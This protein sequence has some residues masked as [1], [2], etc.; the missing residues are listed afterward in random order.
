VV[1]TVSLWSTLVQALGSFTGKDSKKDRRRGRG[2]GANAA[3]PA[4]NR[5]EPESGWLI[6]AVVVLFTDSDGGGKADPGSTHAG[7]EQLGRSKAR[8]CVGDVAGE[9]GGG[10]TSRRGG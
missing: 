3:G 5:H 4:A 7:A 2:A 8:Y 6:V 1:S 9:R 10:Q